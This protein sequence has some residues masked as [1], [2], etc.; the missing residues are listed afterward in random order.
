MRLLEIFKE[1]AK[2]PNCSQDTKKLKEY[3]KSFARDYGRIEEDSAGNIL[4]TVGDPHVCLQAH[5]D[6][7]C[8]DTDGCVE[9]VQKDSII[10]AKNS[11]LGADN[12]VAVAMMLSLIEENSYGEYLF[13]NDEE[14]GLIGANALEL[15]VKSQ[16]IL[17]L[18]EERENIITVGCAGGFDAYYS[19]NMGKTETAN[20]D[21]YEITIEGLPGGH[22]GI[23]IHKTI[24]NALKKVV[25]YANPF[26]KSLVFVESGE[27]HNSIPRS[28]KVVI[29]VE[30]GF[31]PPHHPLIKAEKAKDVKTAFSKKYLDLLLALPH[32][33]LGWLDEYKMP[34]KSTNLAIVKQEGGKLSI[35]LSYRAMTNELLYE[36]QREVE[37]TATLLDL[38]LQTD[39]TYGAWEPNH[40]PFAKEIQKSYGP[41]S[42]IEVIHAG[43][44]GAVLKEKYPDA[45]V[46][47]IGPNIHHPHTANEYAEVDSIERVYKVVK[48]IVRQ[49]L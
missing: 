44:E 45:D 11:S 46:V 6:M 30:K 12:G 4:V 9:V 17:N 47:S 39:T 43:L 36:L 13:T 5:Y 16:K 31:T 19:I 42:K 7:V 2:I 23:E 34:S 24:P 15:N 22:S 33:V 18:D 28:A 40:S 10:K 41:Q 8:I 38:Q 32:G 21:F 25:H 48:K 1:I 27:R 49:A 3:I 29:G 14:I 26:A 35:V 37:A 20:Q